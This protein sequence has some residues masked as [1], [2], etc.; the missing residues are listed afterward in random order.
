MTLGAK[1]QHARQVAGG[2][3]PVSRV[4]ELGAEQHRAE[5][6]AA[7]QVRQQV[8]D[9]GFDKTLR[10]GHGLISRID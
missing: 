10:F 4:Q 5:V 8:H 2:G 1:R 3:R 6:H 9:H 7:E